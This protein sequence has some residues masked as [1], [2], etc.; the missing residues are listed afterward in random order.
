MGEAIGEKTDE[1]S[2]AGKVIYETGGNS[3]VSA[4]M[5]LTGPLASKISSGTII[6]RELTNS[7]LTTS[8]PTT[9]SPTMSC[10]DLNKAKF[11]FKRYSDALIFKK[12]KEGK[13]CKN[14]KKENDI[15][16]IKNCADNIKIADD[17]KLTC[18]NCDN[19]AASPTTCGDLKVRGVRFAYNTYKS[20][21]TIKKKKTG[22]KCK[23]LAKEKKITIENNCADEIIHD[24]C[25]LTCDN[26]GDDSAAPSISVSAAPS[27]SVSAAPSI[28]VTATDCFDID[29]KRFLTTQHNIKKITTQHST[30]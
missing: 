27:I 30:I 10:V 11:T 22:K 21:G 29:G 14:L 13:K 17:C 3:K 26:C 18:E 8:S 28:S 25:K 9:S 6:S 4:T 5:I 24:Y 12:D 2:A 15:T 7:S 20:A 16:I 1:G 23:H 19:P